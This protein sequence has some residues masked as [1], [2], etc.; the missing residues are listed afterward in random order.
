MRPR[1]FFK[2]RR[3]FLMENSYLCQNSNKQPVEIILH[4]LESKQLVN[5]LAKRLNLEVSTTEKLLEGFVEVVGEECRNLNR[6]ALPS[7]G[8]F[9]GVKRDET[10]IRDLSTGKRLL[11]PPAIEIAFT[12]GG[13][14]KN[15]IAE[16]PRK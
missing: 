2:S 14:L 3:G 5:I 13:R 12:P 7:L 15:G 11:L 8:S 10:V 16:G 4:K 1:R 6:V 9:Q